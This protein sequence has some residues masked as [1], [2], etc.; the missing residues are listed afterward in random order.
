MKDDQALMRLYQSGDADAF[1]ELYRRH[2]GRV[3]SYLL[4]RTPSAQD[5]DELLQLVFLKLHQ[6]RHSYDP[7]HLVVQWL[8]VIARHSLIDF[9]R[10]KDRPPVLLDTQDETAADGP[11]IPWNAVTGEQRQALEWRYLDE[12]SY[13]EIAQKLE[14]TEATIRQSISRTIKKLRASVS[15]KGSAT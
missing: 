5:A 9:Y 13:E 4:K 2:A 1:A 11:E 10:K 6:A 12:M 3:R 8:Y 15:S 7:R 14:K